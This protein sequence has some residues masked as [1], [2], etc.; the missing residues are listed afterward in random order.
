MEWNHIADVI[1]FYEFIESVR[2]SWTKKEG[3]YSVE[4]SGYCQLRIETSKEYN[5]QINDK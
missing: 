1:N 5:D 2:F 4:I 3:K